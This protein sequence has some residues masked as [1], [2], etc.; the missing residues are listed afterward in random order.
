MGLT[1]GHG[2]IWAVRPGS[3]GGRG[4]GGGGLG[5]WGSRCTG[6]KRAKGYAISAVH[7]GS[8]G[9]GCAHAIRRRRT[10]LDRRLTIRRLASS[11]HEG[12]AAGMPEGGGARR[13]A[14]R[15]RPNLSSRARFGTRTGSTR[16]GERG[17]LTQGLREVSRVTAVAP[18]RPW[19]ATQC[20]RAAGSAAVRGKNKRKRGR[21]YSPPRQRVG[22]GL[23]NGEVA[24]A[25]IEVVAAA[26]SRIGR[27]LWRWGEGVGGAGE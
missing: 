2:L 5:P 17:E 8:G 26:G 23:S 12:T 1:W 25:E 13:L 18:R 14:R 7:R 27:R 19:R 9:C 15:S 21:A 3:S 6:Y 10:H 20:R 11:A 22:D 24:A 4:R 16:R